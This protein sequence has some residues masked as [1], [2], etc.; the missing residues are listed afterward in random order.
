MAG[1]VSLPVEKP[2]P[3]SVDYTNGFYFRYFA[4]RINGDNYQEISS[5]T[6]NSIKSR[7][8][9]YDHNL[10][11]VGGLKWALRGSNVFSLNANT[12]RNKS[13]FH[14]HIHFTFPILNE[15]AETPEHVLEN[16][17]TDGGELYYGDGTEYTGY[18][19]V[20][21]SQGPM[22]GATHSPEPHDKLYYFHQLPN[23]G[24]S[25]YEDWLNQYNNIHCYKCIIINDTL[26]IVGMTRSRL[27]GCVE[28][29]Y[30]NETEAA[31]NC[32]RINP[33]ENPNNDPPF[34]GRPNP[35]LEGGVNNP[36]WINDVIGDYIYSGFDS[37]DSIGDEINEIVDESN[38]SY[39]GIQPPYGYGTGGQGSTGGGGGGNNYGPSCFI[40]NT[41]ITMADGTEKPISSIE[42]GDKVKSEIGES[43]VLNIQI[44]EGEFS[45]YSIN[46]GKPFVTAEHP[47]KSIDGWKAIDPITTFEKHQ[48]G[49]TTLNLN[50][51]V[52]KL[53]GKEVITN[54]E[55]GFT[56]YPKVYN[57]SLDNEHVFYA[58]GY[59]V[60]NLKFLDPMS[61]VFED[62]VYDR[63]NDW[64]GT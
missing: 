31:E 28:G 16:Q 10:Y 42:I 5:I 33:P 41:L 21:P 30:L 29:S 63:S 59:L 45:V 57:L 9:T 18:Y 23:F 4:K 12:L 34:V 8:G 6:Y 38:G 49:S 43:T 60:H 15:Y 58:N 51:V 19:H 37:T 17:Y 54:I 44:H 11:K 32:P 20:H 52:Y 25:S 27:L 26:Q 24:T 1:Y 56:P 39:D 7:E 46:E 55:K 47:F 40:P 2:K 13:K 50:D 64:I 3:N 22:V 35:P 61:D 48:V 36:V 53:K 62:D 14:P